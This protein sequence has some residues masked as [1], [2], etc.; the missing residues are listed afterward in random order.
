[1]NKMAKVAKEFNI[2]LYSNRSNQDDNE[3][4]SRVEQLDMLLVMKKEVKKALEAMQ[5]GKSAVQD[6]LTADVW[7]NGGEIVLKERNKQQESFFVSPPNAPAAGIEPTTPR[8]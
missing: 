3:R 6:Q 8:C 2:D 1:M 4:G 7:K 5:R